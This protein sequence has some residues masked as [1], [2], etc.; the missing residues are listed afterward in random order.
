MAE[1]ETRLA[2]A[3]RGEKE[4]TAAL[5]QRVA[6]LTQATLNLHIIST[7]LH[8]SPHISL[9]QRIAQLTQVA[10]TLTLTLTLTHAPTS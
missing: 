1:L 6:Q 8:I 3:A 2:A 5:A 10:L 9:A 4:R 7:Y